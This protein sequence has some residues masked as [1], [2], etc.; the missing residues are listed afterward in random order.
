MRYFFL[1][2]SFGFGLWGSVTH[3]Q[4][5]VII[6]ELFTSQGCHSC[7]P[8]DAYAGELAKRNGV[9]PLSLHVDYWDYL[10]WRDPFAQA[11]FTERQKDYARRHNA[12]SVFT[13]QM[14][15]AGQIASVGHD[16]AAVEAGIAEVG[17]AA[18][19]LIIRAELDGAIL[20]I[21]LEPQSP[22]L[23]GMIHVVH[24]APLLTQDIPRGENKGRQISYTNVVR[25]WRTIASWNGTPSSFSAPVTERDLAT[26]VIVQQ[27]ATGPILAAVRLD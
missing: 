19:P 22:G 15:V 17:R 20:N 8:A 24:F 18:V 10:G 2:V 26:A 4:Q 7:P 23:S 11:A 6:A 3:A 27:N 14:I 12:R 21:R 5:P 16:R 25:E 9:L 1:L 13:P